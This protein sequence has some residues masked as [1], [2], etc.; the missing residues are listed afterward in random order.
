MEC[1]DASE[2]LER[3]A[4]RLYAM[5]ADRTRHWPLLQG[6]FLRLAD[7]EEQHALRIQ[8]LA[9]HLAPERWDAARVNETG[10]ALL[11]MESE[12]A[13]LIAD[14]SRRP[15]FRDSAEILR[16]VTAFETRIADLPAERM[17]ALCPPEVQ[18]LF[19]ALAAQDLQ[20]V[21]LLEHAPV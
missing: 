13:G 10:A 6:L 11:A 2:R 17:A 3:L 14:L 9:R 18:R 1:L 15:D 5:L 16:L 4:Q 7:E 8:T 20:H 19:T 12:L 21:E